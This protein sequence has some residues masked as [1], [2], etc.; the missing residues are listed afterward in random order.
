V[1]KVRAGEERQKRKRE[2]EVGAV[3]LRGEF[4]EKHPPKAV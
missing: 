1:V 2:N 4:L 3:R